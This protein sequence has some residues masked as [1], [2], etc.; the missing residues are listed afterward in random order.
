VIRMSMALATF[1]GIVSHQIS[2]KR[3][4]IRQKLL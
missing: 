4:V 1:Q 2:R 3:C